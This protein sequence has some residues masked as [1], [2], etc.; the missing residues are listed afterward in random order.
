M[1]GNRE[2]FAMSEMSVTTDDS[3]VTRIRY[4]DFYAEAKKNQNFEKLIMATNPE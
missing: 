3:R 1:A 2:A 4:I